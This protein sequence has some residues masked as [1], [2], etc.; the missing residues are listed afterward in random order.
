[1]KIKKNIKNWGNFPKIEAS[2]YV[3][4]DISRAK[5]ILLEEET[6]LPRGNARSYGDAALNETVIST[7]P[8]QYFLDFNSKE[9]ILKCQAGVLFSDILDFVV[10]Y[11]Y[12]LP[13]T[14][15]TKFITVGGAIAADVHGKNHHKEG[16]F[17]EFVSQ[18]SII[19]P[20]GEILSCSRGENADIFWETIGGMGLT[21][22]IVEATF[23]LKKIENSY[24][25]VESIK[26]KNLDE[27]MELFEAS[28]DWT[29]TVA[30]I[31][32]LQ[33][34]KHIGRSIIMRGEHA[35]TE[36]LSENQQKFKLKTST[37]KAI[38]I[39]FSF[40]GFALNAVSVKAFN[41]LF[42]NK[43][44]SKSTK[45]VVHYEPFFYPLDSILEWNKIYGKEGFIQY[46]FVIPKGI[47]REALRDILQTIAQSK[48]GSFLAVL[49]L[50]G[51]NNQKAYNSFPIE[52][53]TLALDFKV[54]KRLYQLVP[55]LDAIVRKYS[56]RVYRAKD[57]LSHPKLLDY[58][59]VRN[60]K[61]NSVQNQR[62]NNTNQ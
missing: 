53:Y 4:D 37:A 47:G 38:K 56:G 26:A 16:C 34:G 15:G 55:K 6:V 62:I 2:E 54:N 39:P 57:S 9:G 17:S 59:K 50:F 35:K 20:S 42:Y 22:I 52:G 10:P 29:Y 32:C 33:K 46:Q 28:E 12:F 14:P 7:L 25:Y 31:D 36:Q 51:K 21:G 11:G 49:K 1:M 27:I 23:Q 24:I 5:D 13:V 19:L 45:K 41:W 43:Q 44:I 3:L 58:V 8:L 40:P 61:F 48:Q 18:F 60:T 30:W